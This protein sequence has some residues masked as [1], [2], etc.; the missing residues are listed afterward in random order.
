[1]WDQKDFYKTV[2][3]FKRNIFVGFAMQELWAQIPVD[4][5]LLPTHL[6]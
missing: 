3:I 4:H 2:N 5:F 6:K 1:M